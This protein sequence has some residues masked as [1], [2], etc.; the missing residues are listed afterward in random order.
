MKIED[1][2]FRF[3]L[4]FQFKSIELLKYSIW[5][6]I[7]SV[8]TSAQQFENQFF[9]PSALHLEP[10]PHYLV[11]Y[12]MRLALCPLHYALHGLAPGPQSPGYCDPLLFSGRLYYF[13]AGIFHSGNNRFLILRYNP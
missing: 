4:S 10:Y 12:A 13:K 7:I 8:F 6:H 3:A 5:L 11:P 9:L 1:L 2:W